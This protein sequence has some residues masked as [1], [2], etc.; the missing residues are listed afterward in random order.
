[1]D[2]EK[3]K[4]KKCDEN[5]YLIYL[6]KCIICEN[7]FCDNCIYDEKN[8]QDHSLSNLTCSICYET[9]GKNRI[10][11]I[12]YNCNENRKHEKFNNLYNNNLEMYK[13]YASCVELSEKSK[14]Y[15]YVKYKSIGC[16][17]CEYHYKYVCKRRRSI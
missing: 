5:L 9:E 7:D 3:K 6:E 16:S 15:H 11:K 1:M 2:I 14:D 13:N 8:S 10:Q 12:C 17:L 4:C